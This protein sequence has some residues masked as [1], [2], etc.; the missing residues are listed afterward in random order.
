MYK[1]SIDTLQAVS[2]IANGLKI[3]QK[4]IGYA[5]TKDKRAK[6]TQMLTFFWLVFI[7]ICLDLTL[8]LNHLNFT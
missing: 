3:N 6:T 7:R 8:K 5:G 1:D 4:R 2:L